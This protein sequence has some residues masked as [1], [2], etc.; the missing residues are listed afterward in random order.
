MP[1]AQLSYAHNGS[2]EQLFTNPIQGNSFIHVALH[3][4]FQVAAENLPSG[5]DL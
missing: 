1:R 5:T 3:P 2:H 4:A